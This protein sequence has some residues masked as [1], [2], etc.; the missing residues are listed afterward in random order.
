MLFTF[1]FWTSHSHLIWVDLLCFAASI[2]L[3]SLFLYFIFSFLF[4][5][6]SH[7]APKSSDVNELDIGHFWIS[8]NQT[9][10]RVRLR[11]KNESDFLTDYLLGLIAEVVQ[12]YTSSKKQTL[13]FSFLSFFGNFIWASTMLL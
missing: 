8:L 10:E 9:N 13:Q 2:G 4:F 1:F 12:K 11:N 3:E 6:Q 5:L 7:R